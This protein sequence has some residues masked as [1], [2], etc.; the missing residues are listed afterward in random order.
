MRSGRG[1]PVV[2]HRALQLVDDAR[3]QLAQLEVSDPRS[4]VAVVQA[5]VVPERSAG[6]VGGGVLLEPFVGEDVERLAAAVQLAERTAALEQPFVRPEVECILR[7]VE[8]LG[9]R[10]SSPNARSSKRTPRRVRRAASAAP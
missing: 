6:E 8:L 1:D 3:A 9:A 2:E 10:G 4:Q 7:R 5:G